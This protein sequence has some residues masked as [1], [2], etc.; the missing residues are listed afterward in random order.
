MPQGSDDGKR[1]YSDHVAE[2]IDGE[3]KRLVAEAYDRALAVVQEHKDVILKLS[4]QLLKAEFLTYE[5]LL[6]ALGPR[7]DGATVV[8]S[9]WSD[10]EEEAGANGR[11]G[12]RAKRGE[13]AEPPMPE[14]NMSPEA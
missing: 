1:K 4:E 11:R 2:N 6:S 5:D 9:N 12:R 7:P 10:L 3:A 8:T 13:G 14:S